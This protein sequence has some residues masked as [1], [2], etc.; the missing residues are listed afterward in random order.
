MAKKRKKVSGKR[1]RT[2][3]GRIDA[4]VAK[5]SGVAA[6]KNYKPRKKTGRK[7]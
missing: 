5:A 4:A 2:R 6:P 7:K 3:A 1:Q